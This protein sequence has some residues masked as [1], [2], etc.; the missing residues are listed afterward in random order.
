MY[1]FAL[2]Q[3][4]YAESMESSAGKMKTHLE[5]DKLSQMRNQRKETSFSLFKPHQLIAVSALGEAQHNSWGSAEG[6]MQF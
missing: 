2:P 3:K 4:Y 5:V 6:N 1:N